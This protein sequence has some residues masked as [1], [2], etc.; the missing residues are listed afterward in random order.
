MLREGGSTSALL[1]L[2]PNMEKV[3]WQKGKVTWKRSGGRERSCLLKVISCGFVVLG[4]LF[5][6][7]LPSLQRA[8]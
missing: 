5:S 2:Q 3:Y 7:I 6:R 4:A 1:P 8:K